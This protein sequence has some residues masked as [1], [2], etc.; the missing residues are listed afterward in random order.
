MKPETI[1]KLRAKLNLTD[2]KAVPDEEIVER[3]AA[4]AL[5]D[6][7]PDKSAEVAALSADVTRLKGELEAEKG[8]VLKL[9]ADAPREP[10]ALSLSLITESFDT[11]R[12]QAI[13]DGAISK[14][15][16]DA[17]DK[18]LRPGGKP[19]PLALSQS[20]GDTRPLYSRIYEIIRDN[21]GVRHNNGVPRPGG[22]P[23]LRLSGDGNNDDPAK[24]AENARRE[25][26]AWRDEQLRLRGLQPA[27]AAK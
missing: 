21:P 23:A 13:A 24:L 20:A 2:A 17:L 16:A 10:D 26:E 7:P 25:G 8:K 27:G 22:D 12:D 9:S 14:A 1:Q 18:L 11:K 4:L 5:A 6:P 3:A 15:G 19:T